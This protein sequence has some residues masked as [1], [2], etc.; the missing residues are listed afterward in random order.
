MSYIPNVLGYEKL[1]RKKLMSERY[2]AVILKND[3][4][5]VDGMTVCFYS[6]VLMTL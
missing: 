6:K 4:K 5:L 3:R 1:Q 2:E